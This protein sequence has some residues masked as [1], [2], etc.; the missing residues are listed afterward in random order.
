MLGKDV[1]EILEKTN[2]ALCKHNKTDM[3]VTIWMGIFEFSSAKLTACNAGHEF[4][5]LLRNGKKFE[6]LRDHHS[7]FV[8]GMAET[9]YTPYTIDMEVGDKIFLYTDGVPE[10]TNSK[11]KLFGTER[12]IDALNID[13]NQNPEDIIKTVHD[14][15]N[16][17]VGNAE[18]FDDI[19]MMCFEYKGKK[20]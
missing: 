6:L 12:M 15:V 16:K 5:A 18:Q 11:N 7:L 2:D 20:A 9:Q 10:A 8:G 4:P 17:F 19:T 14:S 13:P 3:F 1:A